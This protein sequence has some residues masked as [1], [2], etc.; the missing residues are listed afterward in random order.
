MAILKQHTS[1]GSLKCRICE[2]V[3]KRGDDCYMLKDVYVSPHQHNLGFHIDCFFE[4]LERVDII[5]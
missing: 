2:R 5:E 3:I 1:N 4:E